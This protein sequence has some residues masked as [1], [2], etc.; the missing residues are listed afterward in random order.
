MRIWGETSRSASARGNS[1][2]LDLK[3]WSWYRQSVLLGAGAQL[4]QGSDLRRS[5]QPSPASRSSRGSS[6]P[7][8]TLLSCPQEGPMIHSGAVI[9][10]GI[11]QGRSTSLKRDFKVGAQGC[12]A[13]LQGLWTCSLAVPIRLPQPGDECCVA[14]CALL[15]SS[16]GPVP[17]SLL[18]L[19]VCQAMAPEKWHCEH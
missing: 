15:S 7:C 17:P 8:L 12:G 1:P 16:K 19:G 10:A 3:R 9:A 11:S 18:R 13:V 4:L 5:R 2:G 14:L 6:F